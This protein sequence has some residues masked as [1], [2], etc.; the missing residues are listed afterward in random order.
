MKW[1]KCLS[2]IWFLFFLYVSFIFVLLSFFF[3]FNMHALNKFLWAWG[4]L[5]HL[6]CPKRTIT[7]S[8]EM[9][10]YFEE[11]E[12][13]GSCCIQGSVTTLPFFHVCFQNSLKYYIFHQMWLVNF[14]KFRCMERGQKMWLLERIIIE[15]STTFTIASSPT[16]RCPML[17]LTLII[18]KYVTITLLLIIIWLIFSHSNTSRLPT[19]NRK[20]KSAH[21]KL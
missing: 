1:K 21:I 3:V 6:D 17:T 5:M 10:C 15:K 7:N 16:G 2:L 4:L 19:A 20:H 13:L 9:A 8:C 14:R 11:G 12:I 18:K